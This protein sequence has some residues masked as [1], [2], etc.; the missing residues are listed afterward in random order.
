MGPIL[1]SVS[2]TGNV[3]SY[4]VKAD[5]EIRLAKAVD[6]ISKLPQEKIYPIGSVYFNVNG[7]IR[8]RHLDLDLERGQR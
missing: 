2:V 1:A 6:D 8:L 3:T 7:V 5:N 4:N